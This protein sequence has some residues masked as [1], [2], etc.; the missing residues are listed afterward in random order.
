MKLV[1]SLAATLGT[2]VALAATALAQDRPAEVTGTTAAP[3][4]VAAGGT[5]SVRVDVEVAPTHHIYGLAQTE[6]AIPPK[7]H[8]PKDGWPAGFTAL[9]PSES[10]APESEPS[11]LGP[12]LVHR[13]KVSFTLPFRVAEDAAPG[14][15][16]L[17]G[18]I[19]LQACD[20]KSC[21]PPERFAFSVSVFVTEPSTVKV[22][23]VEF[24]PAAA[25]A[26]SN[27]TLEIEL[28]MAPGWHLYGQTQVAEKPPSFTWTLPDGWKPSGG[29]VEVTPPHDAKL[30][31]LEETYSVH[32]GRVV[33]RQ[34]FAVPGGQPLGKV[35]IRG[36]GSWQRCD[37]KGCAD[38]VGVP[39]AA[40]LAIV[41]AGEVPAAGQQA[42]PPAPPVDPEPDPAP[43]SPAKD[44]GDLAS[45]LLSGIGWGFITVLTPCVFPLLPVTVSF[46][47]KQK[48]PALPR[49]LVYAAGIIFTLTVIGLAF[50]GSLDLFSRGTAFNLFVGLLFITLALS[51]FGLFE[52]RLPT[53]LIDKSQARGASGG[54]LGAFFMAVTLALTSFSCSVPFLALMFSQFD[55]GEFVVSILGLLAYSATVALPFFLCSLFPTL[56]KAMPRSGG[57]LNAVKVTMGFVELAL[58]FKFLRTVALNLGSDSLSRGL[59]LAIWTA[60]AIGAAIY[61]FGYITLPHDTKSESIGVVRLLFALTFVTIALYLLPGIFGRPLTPAIDGFL[62]T[63]KSDIWAGSSGQSTAEAPWPRNDWDGALARVAEKKRPALFDFTGVG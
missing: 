45:V 5:V 60:C 27:A 23:R 11:A 58:A 13:G 43:K 62:Q 20:E 19:E 46:F 53:F 2:L 50:K 16:E 49:S 55:K 42:P 47:S 36:A 35:E 31:G 12:M 39:V 41:P 33:L 26:G 10:P 51:L 29:L 48:G 38:D 28:T 21:L 56:L 1:R 3:V 14:K 18:E 54:M 63:E 6:N 57:W 37:D 44:G 9:A 59:V 30:Y 52:L 32:E 40:M 15:R 24:V 25:A 61:L 22:A 17:K 34:A 7:F 8:P 4:P